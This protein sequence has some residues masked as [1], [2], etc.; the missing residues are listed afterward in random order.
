M[1]G[2]HEK[3]AE[4]TKNF[5]LFGCF[6]KYGKRHDGK[7]SVWCELGMVHGHLWGSFTEGKDSVTTEFC[8]RY[9]ESSRLWAWH[10]F[11]QV[12][13]ADS[14]GAPSWP[15]KSHLLGGPIF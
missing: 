8:A 11:G 5:A 6:L 3:R 13:M 4:F 12:V 15:S 1:L 2:A 9:F 14:I 7:P 10:F